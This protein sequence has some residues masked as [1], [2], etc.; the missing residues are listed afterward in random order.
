MNP[1][2]ET[3]WRR[4]WG[5]CERCFQEQSVYLWPHL[6]R[7]VNLMV[8]LNISLFFL[9]G[10]V[11]NRGYYYPVISLCLLAAAALLILLPLGFQDRL[12]F[13]LM[14]LGFCLLSGWFLGSSIYHWLKHGGD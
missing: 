8:M 4:V 10:A 9:T 6:S 11:T 3:W 1:V 13:Y 14:V 7:A 12:P 5:R 2:N